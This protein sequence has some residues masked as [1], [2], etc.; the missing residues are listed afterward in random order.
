MA[1]NMSDKRCLMK[2]IIPEVDFNI[3]ANGLTIS[4]SQRISTPRF[5]PFDHAGRCRECKGSEVE[6]DF[7]VTKEGVTIFCT[8]IKS[9]TF[10]PFDSIYDLPGHCFF[11][12]KNK[13]RIFNIQHGVPQ[14]TAQPL[15]HNITPEKNNI[16]PP[17]S[18]PTKKIKLEEKPPTEAEEEFDQILQE[19]FDNI[20]TTKTTSSATHVDKDKNEVQE[21][22]EEVKDREKRSTS[23]PSPLIESLENSPLS[24]RFSDAVNSQSI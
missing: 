10:I 1:I 24:F 17:A 6:L 7:L 15:V 19:F 12:I 8:R 23:D 2:Q 9:P 16:A 20:G 13:G 3:T 18:P 21:D 14:C 4:A 5:V 11:K 22:L